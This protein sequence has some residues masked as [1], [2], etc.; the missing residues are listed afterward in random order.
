MLPGNRDAYMHTLSVWCAIVSWIQ[1][2]PESHM[3]APIGNF[4][5]SKFVTAKCWLCVCPS[6]L[7]GMSGLYN[8]KR[9]NS[10]ANSSVSLGRY[11]ETR[12]HQ[13]IM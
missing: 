1:S 9:R 2:M 3:A 4:V 5:W 11:A 10:T 7:D 6:T 12:L 13:T 8:E